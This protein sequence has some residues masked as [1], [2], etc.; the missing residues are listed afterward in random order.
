MKKISSFFLCI[1]LFCTLQAQTPSNFWSPQAIGL[2]PK[3]YFILGMSVVN[4]DVVWAIAD[5]TYSDPLPKTFVPRLLR[6]INGGTTWQ[7]LPIPDATARLGLDI[8]A[9]DANV[10]WIATQLPSNALGHNLFKTTDGGTTW[11]S[12]FDGYATSLFVRFFDAK[13]GIAWNRQEYALT[14]NGGDTWTRNFMSG[15]SNTEGFASAGI[16]NQCIIIGDTIMSGT[17]TSRIC[18]SPDRGA[19]WKFLD[20]RPV[21]F[22]GEQVIILSLAFK[23]ARNG[24]ALGWNQNSGITYLAKTTDG[25]TMWTYISTYPFTLGSAIEYIRS[26][27]NSYLITD[28]DGLTAYTTNA[29]QSWVKIDSTTSAC[30]R[31]LDKQT[32]WI[33]TYGTKV[34]GPA[35]YKW[36]GGIILS[37]IK[38]FEAEEIA[39]KMSPN[40]TSHFLTVEYSADFK[41]TSLSIYDTSGKTVLV[42]KNLGISSQVI[43]LQGFTNGFYLVQLKNTEGVIA[44][45]IVVE[46]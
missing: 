9:V 22:F 33:G 26:T 6:T 35:M 36:N 32:G 45:K 17:S 23:D 37:A 27:N 40:P 39:L 2:L 13:N 41:P 38:V 29:G 14:Q 25:G 18:M 19:T 4:K 46:Q 34:G 28:T 10:A 24:I 5:S 8:H 30:I 20:L 21:S 11:V 3:D 12:K 44:R 16:S 43:D 15:W 7:V 1:T 42:E 31:F